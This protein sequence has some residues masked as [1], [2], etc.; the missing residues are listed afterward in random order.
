MQLHYE[1]TSETQTVPVGIDGQQ[2][3]N[4]RTW[5]RSGGWQAVTASK[6]LLRK[7]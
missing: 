6:Y 2:A 4:R 1:F 5:H 3:G 7:N